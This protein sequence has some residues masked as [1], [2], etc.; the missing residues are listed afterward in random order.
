MDGHGG[1]WE[2]RPPLNRLS[3]AVPTPKNGLWTFGLAIQLPGFR[4]RLLKPTGVD[5]QPLKPL[6]FSGFPAF[7]ARFLNPRLSVKRFEKL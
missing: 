7:L 1:D 5:H 2:E 3:A 6:A 4:L